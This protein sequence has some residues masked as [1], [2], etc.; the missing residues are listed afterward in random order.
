[1]TRRVSPRTHRLDLSPARRA[2][3][4]ASIPSPLM[5]MT[6]NA[7]PTI[8]ASSATVVK[9]QNLSGSNVAAD[10]FPASG[11]GRD[12]AVVKSRNGMQHSFGQW[13]VMGSAGELHSAKRSPGL[14]GAERGTLMLGFALRS[15][16]HAALQQPLFEHGVHVHERFDR[17][18]LYALSQQAPKARSVACQPLSGKPQQGSQAEV[19]AL[20]HVP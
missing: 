8:Q 14:Y 16:V 2:R 4:Y 10:G 17:E 5:T 9:M 1:M 15:H 12:G 7:A 3:P 18:P 19:A 20:A 6:M 13:G 11:V